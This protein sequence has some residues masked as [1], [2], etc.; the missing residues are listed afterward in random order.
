MPKTPWVWG[1]LPSF[2]CFGLLLPTTLVA[3]RTALTMPIVPRYEEGAEYRWLHKKVLD[4]RLL[5][6]MEN[7]SSWSFAGSG[8]MTL[9]EVRASEPWT[10][11]GNTTSNRVLRLHST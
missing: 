11:T 7:L 1:T 9:V 3:Q 4:S 8:E 2:I 6:D 10:M 5:D